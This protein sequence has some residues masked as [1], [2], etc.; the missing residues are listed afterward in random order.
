MTKYIRQRA[1][2]IAIAA[3]PAV[4]LLAEV[5]GHRVP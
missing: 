2:T 3:I 5:A 1:L 4:V